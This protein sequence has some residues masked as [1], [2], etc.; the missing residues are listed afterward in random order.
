MNASYIACVE[1]TIKPEHV[2]SF[3][4][5][6]R[7]KRLAALR[8]PGFLQF[9]ILRSIEVEGNFLLVEA[10]SSDRIV[11]E[12]KTTD[13]YQQWARLVEP[14]LSAPRRTRR[15]LMLTQSLVG[16]VPTVESHE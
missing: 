15:Y 6:T 9:E 12:Y 5:A 8:H 3:I 2:E 11:Q 14:W 4:L 13:G 10:Y 1:V 16:F 7:E